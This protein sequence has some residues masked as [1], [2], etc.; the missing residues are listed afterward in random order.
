M[1]SAGVVEAEM[2]ADRGASLGDRV[3]SSKVDLLALDRSPEP[4]DED[5][6]APG[7]LA[8]HA[9]GDPV[10]G[11]RPGEGP[12]G[13]LAALVGVEDLRPAVADQSLFQ[14]LDAERRLQGDRQPP[15][16]NPTAE[17]V[18]DR[19]E[20]DEPARHRNVGGGSQARIDRSSSI[21][22]SSAK[23]AKSA[24]EASTM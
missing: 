19:G 21:P 5:V 14:R 15:G 17:P 20:V 23:R 3:V 16:E 18:D 6:V 8:V 9:D 13:E 7:T 11:Q 24:I 12:A 4:L 1:R 10:L 2:P 22:R